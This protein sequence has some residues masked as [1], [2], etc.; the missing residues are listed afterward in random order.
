MSSQAVLSSLGRCFKVCIQAPRQR[1]AATT[2]QFRRPLAGLSKSPHLP[3][4][5]LQAPRTAG[6]GVVW[7]VG[8]CFVVGTGQLSHFLKL[9]GLCSKGKPA[10]KRRNR[11]E[12]NQEA[13]VVREKQ[14]RRG[15]LAR[16]PSLPSHVT[17][18]PNGSAAAE[19]DPW[20][21]EGRGEGNGAGPK[22]P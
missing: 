15:E 18:A 8:F 9:R 10:G 14:L 11:A 7:L 3:L 4:S 20:R 2:G 1:E 13:A 19:G 16:P 12:E 22:T 5:V 21:P 6:F 17:R